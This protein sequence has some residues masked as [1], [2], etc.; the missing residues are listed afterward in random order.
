MVPAMG[1][2][3]FC[4]IDIFGRKCRSFY[5]KR[6]THH[7]MIKQVILDVARFRGFTI[8]V[9]ISNICGCKHDS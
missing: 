7:D 4:D 3:S 8:R 9:R 5:P 2:R 1:L 6:V